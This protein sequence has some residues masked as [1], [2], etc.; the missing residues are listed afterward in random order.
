M[1]C[2]VISFREKQRWSKPSTSKPKQWTRNRWDTGRKNARC[3]FSYFYTQY[4][5]FLC[6]L[7]HENHNLILLKY[8]CTYLYSSCEKCRSFVKKFFYLPKWGKQRLNVYNPP[9]FAPC[10]SDWADSK[11]VSRCQCQ[12]WQ[13]SSAETSTSRKS[14]CTVE[15]VSCDKS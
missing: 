13:P 3:L 4:L 10:Q 15:A 1:L 6:V 11:H 9:V 12:T 7:W 8:V 5:L 14:P 2:H